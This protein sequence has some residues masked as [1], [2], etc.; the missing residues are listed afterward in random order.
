ME[1]KIVIGLTVFAGS[2]LA[3][4]GL[5]LLE[6]LPAA[7]LLGLSCVFMNHFLISLWNSKIERLIR[8]EI[9]D[10]EIEREIDWSWKRKRKKEEP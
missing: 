2:G 1:R 9:L 6:E 5:G 3:G 8:K 10:K 7:A 4:G